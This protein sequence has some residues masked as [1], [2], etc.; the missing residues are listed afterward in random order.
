MDEYQSYRRQYKNVSSETRVKAGTLP[1]FKGGP[2]RTGTLHTIT[3][4]DPW[5]QRR[6][7]GLEGIFVQ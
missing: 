2:W 1:T 7:E 3:T 6:Y 5:R 4:D